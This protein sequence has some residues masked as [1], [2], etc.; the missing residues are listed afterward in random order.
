MI[1]LLLCGDARWSL[2]QR[3]DQEVDNTRGTTM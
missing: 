2:R 1:A 3:R